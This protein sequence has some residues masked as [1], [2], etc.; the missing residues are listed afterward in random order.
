M[1]LKSRLAGKGYRRRSRNA[2]LRL[3]IAHPR[4][5]LSRLSSP[6]RSLWLRYGDSG[7]DG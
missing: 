2:S 4:L 6:L 3:R 5:P 7:F 1:T